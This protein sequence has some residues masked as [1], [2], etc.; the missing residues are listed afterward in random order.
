[1]EFRVYPAHE[2]TFSNYST[3]MRIQVFYYLLHIIRSKNNRAL[4]KDNFKLFY[5]LSICQISV[6]CITFWKVLA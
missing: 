5:K 3:R 6:D 4:T 2:I 1:M